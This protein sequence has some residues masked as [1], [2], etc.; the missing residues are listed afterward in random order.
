VNTALSTLS[1]RTVTDA[2]AGWVLASEIGLIHLLE[3]SP[4]DKHIRG[5]L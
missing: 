2:H 1:D 5:N 4:L 3:G